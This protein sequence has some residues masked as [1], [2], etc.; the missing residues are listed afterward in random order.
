MLTT[1]TYEPQ[2]ALGDEVN[3]KGQLKQMIDQITFEVEQK[4]LAVLAAP[5][6]LQEKKLAV[7]KV[8]N[9]YKGELKNLEEGFQE[10]QIDRG[11]SKT[12]PLMY[13]EEGYQKFLQAN[14]DELDRIEDM[15]QAFKTGMSDLIHQIRTLIENFKNSLRNIDDQIPM[16]V[17][18]TKHYTLT[19]MWGLHDE[20]L[21]KGTTVWPTEADLKQIQQNKVIKDLKL[22]KIMYYK[23]GSILSMQ[24]MLNDGTVSPF[25]GDSGIDRCK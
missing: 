1:L 25:A 6:R 13:F 20:S 14:Q 9:K 17:I 15:K 7:E 19:N 16:K 12:S 11:R 21:I 23:V 22:K 8:F 10:P 4:E 3:Y 2:E 24:F 5:T 18:M